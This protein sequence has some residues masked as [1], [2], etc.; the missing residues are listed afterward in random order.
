[1][2]ALG[3]LESPGT[4]QKRELPLTVLVFIKEMTLTPDGVCLV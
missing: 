1:M 4:K 3:E 2:A